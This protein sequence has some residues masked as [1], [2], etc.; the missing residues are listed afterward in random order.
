MLMNTPAISVVIPV[1]N[2]EKYIEKCISSLLC[3]T[4]SNI[5]IIVV[6]DG[7]TDRTSSIAHNMQNQDDRIVVI[8]KQNEGVSVAR[9]TA[10]RMAK[11]EWIAFSDADDYYY[12]NG[13]ALLYDVAK[14]T[15]CKIVLGNSDRLSMD[16]RKSQRYPNLKNGA[17]CRDYPK[18]SHEMWG[19]LFHA[20]LFDG[21]EYAF[22]PGLAYLEDRLLMAKLFSKEGKYA[23]CATQVYA[24]VKNDGSVLESKNGLRMA[25]H[26]FWAASLMENYSKKTHTFAGEISIDAEQAKNRGIIYF[27]KQ[28]NAPLSELKRVFY[29]YFDSSNCFCKYLLRVKVDTWV[30]DIKR[31]ISAFSKKNG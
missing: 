25:K 2:G 1:Y 9:N 6:N 3:Q 20:S 24:H 31:H 30:R 28:K 11:G 4:F 17:I 15:G 7:S 26:C 8:D 14:E 22:E 29:H 21:D 23:T 19:D 5:E 18:G 13:I 27:F 16:G 10:L 12:P